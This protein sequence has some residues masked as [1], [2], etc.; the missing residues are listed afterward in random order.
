M[1]EVKQP[2]MTLLP[3]LPMTHDHWKEVY[4][5]VFTWAE[6]S[7][8]IC[9]L[10][11]EAESQEAI[12]RIFADPKASNVLLLAFVETIRWSIDR[13]CDMVKKNGQKFKIA[14][15]HLCRSCLKEWKYDRPFLQAEVWL[16]ACHKKQQGVYHDVADLWEQIGFHIN[17]IYRGEAGRPCSSIERI[18]EPF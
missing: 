4:G 7:L 16:P 8:G 5:Y 12:G 1:N 11:S 2:T 6:S 17:L 10:Q 9:R 13:R 3:M 14:E 15:P 18:G